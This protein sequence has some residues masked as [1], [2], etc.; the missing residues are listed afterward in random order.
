MALVEGLKYGLSSQYQ[1]SQPNANNKLPSSNKSV[2]FVKLTDSALKAIE[3]Y[4]KS[5][6]K[7][8]LVEAL[9][10]VILIWRVLYIS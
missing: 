1:N 3:E 4:L 10:I 5:Q 8:F 6:V 9:I 2:L 7:A